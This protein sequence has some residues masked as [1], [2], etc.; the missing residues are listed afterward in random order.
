M[1]HFGFPSIEQFRNIVRQVRD[2][3]EY[4]QLPLPK[5]WFKGTVKI[6]GTNAGIVNDV[7]T[8]EIWT[9]S[10]EQLITPKQDNAGF[11]AFVF[12]PDNHIL[13][14]KLFKKAQ[15]LCVEEGILPGFTHIAIFGEWCG[16]GIMKNV[17][18]NQLEKRFV[19]FGIR[20]IKYEGENEDGAIQTLEW[21]T[22]SQVRQV[23]EIHSDHNVF[24]IY[25]FKNWSIQIDFANPELSV[26]KMVELTNEVEAECPVGAAFGAI[27]VGEG[28]VWKA[29]TDFNDP[30]PNLDR[31]IFKVKGAKHS[32]SH[33]KVQAEVDV[34][35]VASIKAFANVVVTD[36]RL[37][38]MVEK[39]KE[40]GIEV[41]VKNTGEFLKLVG[42]DVIKEE[43]DRL[44]ASGFVWKDVAGA[45]NNTAKQWWMKLIRS[46]SGIA[47]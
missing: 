12:K 39:L 18:V 27:G 38:K 8:G 16:K 9:Q 33:T 15:D 7:N 23:I 28:I 13:F 4:H 42:Q 3:C 35:K 45:V 25:T 34:E 2:T 6:H 1:K 20:V 24:N 44:E 32:D 14:T 37:E 30:F 26:N 47:L 41:D 40:A 46:E 17:A 29:I 22:D 5:I 21:L 10:R 19:V 36:H 11:A 43:T 31:L